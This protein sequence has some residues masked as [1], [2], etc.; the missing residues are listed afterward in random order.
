MITTPAVTTPSDRRR[1]L[2]A[3]IVE[4][5]IYSALVSGYALIA[6]HYCGQW[7]KDLYDHHLYWYAVVA[8]GIMIG[9]GL[10]LELVT[11]FIFRLLRRKKL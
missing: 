4:T 2:R 7:M 9:Q 10:M 1:I 11:T 5:A 3:F 6:L 8:L